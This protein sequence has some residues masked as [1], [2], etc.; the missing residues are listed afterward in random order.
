MVYGVGI[1]LNNGKIK[2]L[3]VSSILKIIIGLI[4]WKFVPGWI[5]QGK[6]NVRDVIKMACN[7]IGIIMVLAGGYSLVMDL[8]EH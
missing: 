2:T 7:I 3:M 5:T 6:K 8:I 4:V 1:N